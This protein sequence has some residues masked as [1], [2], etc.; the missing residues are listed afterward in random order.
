[1]SNNTRYHRNMRKM[2]VVTQSHYQ[3]MRRI[4]RELRV[5]SWAKIQYHKVM[6]VMITLFARFPLTPLAQKKAKRKHLRACS[7]LHNTP[8]DTYSTFS[9]DTTIFLST[10]IYK[11]EIRKTDILKK[12]CKSTK[13]IEEICPIIYYVNPNYGRINI[14]ITSFCSQ[15]ENLYNPVPWSRCRWWQFDTHQ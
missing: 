1:M 7:L 12:I 5:K 15:R 4:I 2:R 13:Y 6:F 11:A 9:K 8:Q 3:I 10:V 14:A